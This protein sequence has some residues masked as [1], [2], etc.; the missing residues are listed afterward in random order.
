MSPLVKTQSVPV[1]GT[2]KEFSNLEKR[3]PDSAKM[4]NCTEAELIEPDVQEFV[5]IRVYFIVA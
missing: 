5:K 4:L 1:G 2:N 3:G